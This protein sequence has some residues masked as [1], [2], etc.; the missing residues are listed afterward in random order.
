MMKVLIKRINVA[1]YLAGLVVIGLVLSL[2]TLVVQ[3][4]E[5]DQTAVSVSL[6]EAAVRTISQTDQDTLYAYVPTSEQ[7]GIYRSTDR[8]R[9]WQHSGPGPAAALHALTSHPADPATLYAGTAGGPLYETE[10]LWVSSDRGQSWQRFY[11]NLPA[12][13]NGNLPDVT[14]LAVD[15]QRPDEF[16]VGTARQGVYRFQSG[17]QAYGY[18]RL[19]GLDGPG[20]TLT[21]LTVGPQGRLYSL[22]DSGL[23]VL[24]ADESGWQQLDSL[25]DRP[26]SFVVDPNDPQILYSGTAVMGVYRSADGGHSWQEIQTGL[27]R[28]PD[29]SLRVP[30]LAISPGEVSHL[31][32]AVT[33]VVAG[34]DNLPRIETGLYESIDGGQHWLKIA[35][36]PKDVYYLTLD[37][38]TLYAATDQGFFQYTLPERADGL[39]GRPHTLLEHL[40][41]LSQFQLTILGL[42]LA[43]I[44][45][46]LLVRLERYFHYRSVKLDD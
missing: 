4:V 41:S 7:V 31:A 18:E 10:N 6:P 34:E 20:G 11:L 16:Y 25:P 2:G 28:A 24:S 19:G 30:A 9:T 22:T 26:I 15:L 35:D 14:A 29:G 21:Q 32:A 37:A 8:G 39:P 17:L 45:L 43:V 33:T 38:E 40:S 5:D 42:A 3:A 46:V 36:G 1:P 23:Y 13:S 27:D 44:V 12:D